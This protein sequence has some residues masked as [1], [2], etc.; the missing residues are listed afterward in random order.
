M[1]VLE[2]TH[3]ITSLAEASQK[4]VWRSRNM[5]MLEAFIGAFMD[6]DKP[7]DVARILRE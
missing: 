5:I 1:T 4:K 6:S 2:D 7:Q 3:A